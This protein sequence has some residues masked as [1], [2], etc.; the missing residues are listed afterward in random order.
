MLDLEIEAQRWM[1]ANKV[2]PTTERI[3][4]LINL[5]LVVESNIL[6]DIRKNKL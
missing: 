3:T 6:D 2:T 4:T 5:L 1:K